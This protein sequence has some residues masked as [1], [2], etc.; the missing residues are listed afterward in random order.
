M[1]TRRVEVPP[2]PECSEG[3]EEWEQVDE[4]MPQLLLTDSYFE[5]PGPAVTKPMPDTLPFA[6]VNLTWI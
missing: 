6:W 2:G 5:T 1:A 3:D 4:K